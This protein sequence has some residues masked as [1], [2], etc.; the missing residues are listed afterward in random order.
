MEENH[1]IGP[2]K[3]AQVVSDKGVKAIEWRKHSLLN[4]WWWSNGTSTGEEKD[5]SFKTRGKIQE[6]VFKI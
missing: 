4:K 3:Y 2:H 1:E 6:K 5:Q